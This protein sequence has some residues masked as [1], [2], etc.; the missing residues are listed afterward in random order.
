M[1]QVS[2]TSVPTHQQLCS[3]FASACISDN[4]T[5][6]TTSRDQHGGCT[7]F[8]GQ[9]LIEPLFGQL[10]R[11]L[12]ET[13]TPPVALHREVAPG[14]STELLEYI[15]GALDTIVLPVVSVVQHALQEPRL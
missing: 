9:T 11:H 10:V 6:T 1:R 12:G 13:A 7:R 14:S 4:W 8:L 5:R 15:Q 3:L 2:F